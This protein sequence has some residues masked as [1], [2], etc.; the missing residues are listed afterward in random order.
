MHSLSGTYLRKVVNKSHLFVVTL[1]LFLVSKKS[2][3]MFCFKFLQQFL[4]GI[5]IKALQKLGTAM[6]QKIPFFLT[7]CFR[8][9]EGHGPKKSFPGSPLISSV[10]FTSISD[11][12]YL[13][14]APAPEI[15]P[16]FNIY[17]ASKTRGFEKGPGHD[18]CHGY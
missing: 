6:R 10:S 13:P 11:L 2:F 7:K 12:I 1:L 4:Q 16:L 14:A 5:V 18:L 17:S 3:S 9:C 15:Q 8:E